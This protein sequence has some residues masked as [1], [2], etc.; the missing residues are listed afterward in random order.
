MDVSHV[1]VV[2]PCWSLFRWLC[3][4]TFDCVN[5]WF[6]ARLD[7]IHALWIAVGSIDTCVGFSLLEFLVCLEPPLC[8]GWKKLHW[9]TIPTR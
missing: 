2:A 9:Q 1:S 6:D 5:E 3:V 8:G 7:C 4:Q